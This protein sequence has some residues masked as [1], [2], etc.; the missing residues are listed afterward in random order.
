VFGTLFF[1][2]LVFAAWSSAIS[3]VE[4]AVAWLVE[5]RGLERVTACAF[6]GILSWLLGIGS[7]LSFN[8]WSGADY[9]LFGKTVFDIKDYLASNIML[10]LGGL[11]IALF[12]GWVARREMAHDELAMRSRFAFQLWWWLIRFVAPV[13]IVFVFL[14]AVGAI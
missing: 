7:V 11:M 6:V 10:P 1:V 12:S 4:P 2:L 14:N 8:L 13:G 9:Q 3:L 5:N